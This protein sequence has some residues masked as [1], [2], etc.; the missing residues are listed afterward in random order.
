MLVDR[1]Y[2]V[3]DDPSQFG[4][5][6]DFLPALEMVS[7]ASAAGGVPWYAI[8]KCLEH[9]TVT[10][11][12]IGN[13]ST[14]M[15]AP[16][17]TPADIPPHGSRLTHLSYTPSQ[18]RETESVEHRTD[19]QLMYAL[20]SSYL[21]ALVLSMSTTAESLT[22]PAETAPLLEMASMDWPRLHTLSLV[23][24]YTHPNQGDIV[25]LLLLRMPNLRSLSVQV[26][27]CEGTQRP[28]LL[29][30]LPDTNYCL[31]SLTISYPNTE[32]PIFSCIGDGLTSLS[33]RDSPRYY[34]HSRYGQ[35]DLPGVFPILKASE[36]LTIIKRI[37]AP[38]LLVLELVY[39]GDAAENELLQHLSRAF[40]LLEELEL[41][42]YK[43]QPEE[44]VPYLHIARTLTAVK[45]LHAL[46]LNLDIMA[47][48]PRSPTWESDD[49]DNECAEQRDEWGQE[50]A[51]VLQT[52]ETFQ[53]VA[54][55]LHLHSAGDWALYRPPWCRHAR[56]IDFFSPYKT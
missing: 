46:Y 24:R 2:V 48:D 8:K 5:E 56:R 37:S 11:I 38:R 44:N 55:L 3:T 13:N 10:S 6:L 27:Q 26:I 4:L 47:G 18:W 41:H 31:R 14:W 1:K 28:P 49:L 30:E 9:P 45:Y 19:L 51:A 20:E 54:L 40:P 12:S 21:R 29:K 39:K 25:P 52:R 7:F 33:L 50:I 22:L 17:P 15:C 16:P 36:C 43:A 23:G 35:R 34:F 32:D 53:Y 42:R